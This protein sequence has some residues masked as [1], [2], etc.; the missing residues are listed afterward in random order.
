[1][2]IVLYSS[3]KDKKTK[4]NELVQW[5]FKFIVLNVVIFIYTNYLKM[6]ILF[7]H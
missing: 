6:Q 3:N 1:M 5:E 2:D 7:I 4:K